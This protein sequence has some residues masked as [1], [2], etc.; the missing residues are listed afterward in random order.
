MD[1]NVYK[2]KSIY[3]KISYK[4]LTID[5][6]NKMEVMATEARLLY[7]LLRFDF[8]LCVLKTIVKQIN[9]KKGIPKKY[10]NMFHCVGVST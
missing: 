2:S 3:Y 6:E 10:K 1:S 8:E 7:T 5:A 9:I 4:I